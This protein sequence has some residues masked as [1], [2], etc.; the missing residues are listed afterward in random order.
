[1]CYPS[2][3]PRCS[4]HVEAQLKRCKHAFERAQKQG[5]AEDIERT[6]KHLGNTTVEF[7]TTP[8]GQ[9]Y[10]KE[11]I[12]AGE[13]T[14]GKLQKALDRGLAERKAAMQAYK[15][16]DKDSASKSI[17]DSA[18]NLKPAAKDEPAPLKFT[19]AELRSSLEDI[20]NSG[21]RL[22]VPGSLS[23][24]SMDSGNLHI[25]YESYVNGPCV[26]QVSQK[27]Q[28]MMAY[29]DYGDEDEE[30]VTAARPMLQR[31]FSKFIRGKDYG[32]SPAEITAN[33]LADAM[34][35]LDDDKT[36]WNKDSDAVSFMY[37]GEA[38]GDVNSA[39][40]NK[41]YFNQDAIATLDKI[42]SK[43]TLAEDTVVYRGIRDYSGKVRKQIEAGTYRD[44][45]YLS[46]TTNLKTATNFSGGGRNGS[47]VMALTLPAGTKCADFRNDSEAEIALPRSFDLSKAKWKF[48]N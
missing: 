44:D 22:F 30:E 6:R 27:D 17:N 18:K 11:K 40:R 28:S 32:N 21:D 38:H 15:A 8:K 45:G 34:D 39:L 9:K 46:T 33:N 19:A 35:A 1:M 4:Q 24:S 29:K 43:D 12:A 16:L 3:G 5:N 36:D 7:F 42:M 25:R 13:D 10:L 20:N 48:F 23:I 31:K 14:A 26:M 47:I 41:T 37:F 2:P